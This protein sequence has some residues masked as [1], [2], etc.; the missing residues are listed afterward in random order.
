M[1]GRVA[2]CE[3]TTWWSHVSLNDPVAETTA[4]RKNYL[5]QDGLDG[6][7]PAPLQRNARARADILR[8]AQPLQR[9]ALLR[10][11]PLTVLIPRSL[12]ENS[13]FIGAQVWTRSP[14]RHPEFG[15]VRA[16]RRD[17]QNTGHKTAAWILWIRSAPN[18]DFNLNFS[19]AGI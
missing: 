3:W 15:F 6:S 14:Q 16:S 10:L 17:D 7:P 19:S 12:S 13:R 9:A 11:I 5:K 8:H 4:A 2:G 1:L 18:K